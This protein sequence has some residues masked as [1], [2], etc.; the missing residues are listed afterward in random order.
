MVNFQ[1]LVVLYKCRYSVL[2]LF[3]KLLLS[4][5]LRFVSMTMFGIIC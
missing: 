1:S 5:C 4:V 3:Y 2:P